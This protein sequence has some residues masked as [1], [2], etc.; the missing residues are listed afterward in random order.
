MLFSPVLLFYFLVFY[1]RGYDNSGLCDHIAA[2]K[3]LRLA[4]LTVFTGLR[5]EVAIC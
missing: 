5:S 2:V 3:W 1:M 4:S